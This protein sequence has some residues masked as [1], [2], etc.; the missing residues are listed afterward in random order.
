MPSK[1]HLTAEFETLIGEIIMRD[2][3]M[4]L[5]GVL[6]NQRKIRATLTQP[7]CAIEQTKVGSCQFGRRRGPEISCSSRLNLLAS[8]GD[9][10]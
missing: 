9:L 4:T 8:Y 2:I 1:K 5:H 6:T 10:F 7:N 3:T